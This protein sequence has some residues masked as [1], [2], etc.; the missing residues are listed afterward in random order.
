MIQL[1]AQLGFQLKAGMEVGELG[2]AHSRRVAAQGLEGARRIE[3]QVRGVVDLCERPL[4]D[5]G[6]E[7][8]FVEQYIT[9]R[10][11][12]IHTC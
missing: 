11:H 10:K 7:A 5:Q 8:V 3:R 12:F 2:A 1:R 6:F 4:S 9:L